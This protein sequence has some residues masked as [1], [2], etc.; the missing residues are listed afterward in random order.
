MVGLVDASQAVS[1][2]YRYDRF[3][4]SLSAS[5]TNAAANVYRFSS[6]EYLA[7]PALYY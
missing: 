7:N 2:E 6:K 5:G 1:A 3:G 4:R